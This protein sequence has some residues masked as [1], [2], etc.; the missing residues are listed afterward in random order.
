MMHSVYWT[1]TRMRAPLM[2]VCC[3]LAGIGIV[4]IGTK[5]GNQQRSE[6]SSV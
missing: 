3:V 5:F 1:D 6:V 2:P 4:A